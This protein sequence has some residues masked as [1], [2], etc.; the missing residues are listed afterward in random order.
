MQVQLNDYVFEKQGITGT[1]TGKKLLSMLDL[2]RAVAASSG[3]NIGV[4]SDTAKWLRNYLQAMRLE[5][6]EVLAEIP[7]KWWSKSKLD[8]PHIQEEIV[9]CFHFLISATITAGMG[10]EDLVR[11][12]TEKHAKNITRQDQGYVASHDGSKL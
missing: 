12:Y 8:I 6:D 1:G 3:E 11:A 7:F 9:D 4:N 10:P 2:G 5:V